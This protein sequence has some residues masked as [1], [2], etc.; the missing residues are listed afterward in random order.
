MGK[1][2]VKGKMDPNMCILCRNNCETLDHLFFQ[3]RFSSGVWKNV[4]VVLKI[5][6]DWPNIGF[7]F[8]Y[9]QWLQKHMFF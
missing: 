5:D 7:E 8:A 3:C 2:K 6:D 9:K 4:C 1:L